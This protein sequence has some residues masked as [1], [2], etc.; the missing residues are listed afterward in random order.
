VKP[1]PLLISPLT[2][3]KASSQIIEI[4]VPKDGKPGDNLTVQG[5]FGNFEG[6]I[7]EGLK[8]GDKYQVKVNT[9][10]A[11]DEK[12]LVE[13]TV[14]EGKNAG[15]KLA[16]EGALG[17]FEVDIPK[18]LKPGDKFKV[19]IEEPN[20]EPTIVEVAVP[21]D[22]KA[23]DKIVIAGPLGKHEVTIPDG[24]KS[25]DKFQI[26]IDK[27]NPEPTVVEIDVPK[28][29]KAGEKIVIDG[30]LGKFEVTIPDGMKSGDKFTIQVDEPNPEPKVVEVKVPEDGEPGKKLVIDGPLGKFKV[31]IPDGLKHGDTFRVQIEEPNVKP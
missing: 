12:T 22:K 8:P 18:D 14:P 10:N 27:P 3:S 5:S 1:K 29:K 13:V 16:I 30:P 20:P 24:M 21:E 4:T 17:K 11:V 2:M 31:A 26:K 9:E 15:E 19:K 28:D 23:G 6:P 25:G 7:P